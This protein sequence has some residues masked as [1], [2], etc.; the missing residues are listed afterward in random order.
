MDQC[1]LE[2]FV[3]YNGEKKS[4]DRPQKRKV[5]RKIKAEICS[6]NMLNPAMEKAARSRERMSLTS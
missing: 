2:M 4:M 6:Q 3:G 1:F 5:L